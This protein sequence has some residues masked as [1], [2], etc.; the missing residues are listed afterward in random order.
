[1][2]DL[3]SINLPKLVGKPL[4]FFAGFLENR[5]GQVVAIPQLLKDGGII[6]FRKQQFDEPPTYLPLVQPPHVD[7]TDTQENIAYRLDPTTAEW[8]FHTAA[9]Y[10]MAYQSGQTTPLAVAHAFLQAVKQLDGGERP[11]NA[12]ISIN[13]QDLLAQAQASTKRYQ[14]GKMLSPLDGVPIAIKDELDMV[15]YPTTVGTSFWGS[16]PAQNDSTAVSRLR[17]KG[18]LLLGKTNMYEIGISPEGFNAH[19]GAVRNPFNLDHDSGGSSSGSA[20]AVAAGLCPIALGADGGGSIRVP[21]AHCGLVG[22]KAT[23]GRIS[24][25]GAAPLDWSVAHTGPIGQSVSDVALAYHTIAGPD[26]NDENT[27]NQPA[28]K[29]GDLTKTDLSHLKIGVYPDWF[30]HAAPEIVS[31]CQGMLNAYEKAGALIQEIEIP[32][33]DNMRIAHV[34]S[35]LSEMAT[36]MEN[37]KAEKRA[38]G[39]P[40]RVNLTLGRAIT[41]TD[42]VHAQRMRTRALNIFK[43]IFSE[44]DLV[45]TPT[46]AV[47]APSI[48]TNS[49]AIGWNDLGTVTELMRF[50]FVGNLIGCPAIS[51]P[52]GYD[53]DGLPIGMQM[54]ANHWQEHKLFK[55]AVFAEQIVERKRPSV[56]VDLFQKLVA[57]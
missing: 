10:V 44:V 41:A 1:M 50:V 13:E 53:S 27:L 38:F 8:P 31:A 39:A 49:G 2:Y 12:F 36:S 22:L 51:F 20:A 3:K 14:S 32:Q 33:L 57:E 29:L 17:E 55:T 56:W 26:P 37:I 40:T 21:A 6:G 34:I 4:Q 18:A 42:Y 45:A 47:T 23:Y 48:P 15:P 5:L 19:Y 43:S 54:M 35:I 7:S 46:T 11:L 24:G 30:N 25:Y 52:V 28:V 9:D 16:Q